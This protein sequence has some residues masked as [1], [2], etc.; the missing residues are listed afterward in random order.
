MAIIHLL[1][2]MILQVEMH[3]AMVISTSQFQYD[4]FWIYHLLSPRLQSSS[5]NQD[6]HDMFSRES[7]PNL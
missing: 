3:L 7:Q 1:N 5:Q 4:I 6:D 2:G